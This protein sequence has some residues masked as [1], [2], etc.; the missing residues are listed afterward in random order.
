MA[1][2]LSASQLGALR[3]AASALSEQAGR[4]IARDVFVD[5]AARDLAVT[6]YAGDGPVLAL[7]RRLPVA[8]RCSRGGLV[9][10][11]RWRRASPAVSATETSRG[12]S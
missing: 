2:D 5:L 11:A 7:V 6:L 3:R 10:S 8:T 4:G 12:P 1:T 9:A